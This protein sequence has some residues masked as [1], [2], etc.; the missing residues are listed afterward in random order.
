MD[1]SEKTGG[2][3]TRMENYLMKRPALYKHLSALA[4]AS[5]S[6]EDLGVTGKEVSVQPERVVVQLYFDAL[7]RPF[8]ERAVLAI[9]NGVS[10]Q[11]LS[12]AHAHAEFAELGFTLQDPSRLW[13]FISESYGM[14]SQVVCNFS[15]DQIEWTV[16]HD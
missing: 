1:W 12:G 14:G 5:I 6:T 11:L 16:P 10:S 3:V 9:V 13:L 4:Y 15:N 8:D 7:P 2:L